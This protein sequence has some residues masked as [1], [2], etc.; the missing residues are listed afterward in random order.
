[1]IPTPCEGGRLA[2]VVAAIVKPGRLIHVS[3]ADVEIK[4]ALETLTAET[5]RKLEECK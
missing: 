4:T 2:A 1:M 5:E 3:V